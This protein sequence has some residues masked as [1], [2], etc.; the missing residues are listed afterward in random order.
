MYFSV[1]DRCRIYDA[2]KIYAAI[3]RAFDDLSSVHEMIDD[4][5]EEVIRKVGQILSSIGHSTV[6]RIR[7]AYFYFKYWVG[8][9][10]CYDPY[11]AIRLANNARIQA[12]RIKISSLE[13]V[14][15]YRALC[16]LRTQDRGTD[17]NSDSD[18]LAL[19]AA[20]I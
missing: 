1:P 12:R 2:R 6:H 11:N 5:V 18:I 10:F 17:D 4:M 9:S 16:L 7:R 13:Q 20:R 3:Q 14:H 8:K 15:M 19:D